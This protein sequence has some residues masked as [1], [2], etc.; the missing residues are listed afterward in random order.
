MPLTDRLCAGAKP[1]DRPRYLI[2]GEGLYL[3]ISRTGT[4]TWMYRSRTGG[5]QWKKL[6][7]YPAMTL[8][9]ARNRAAEAAGNGF[10]MRTVREAYAEY[11]PVLRRS[12]G[13]HGE[14]E[15]RFH[16]DILPRLGEQQLDRVTRVQVSQALQTIVARGALVAANRTLPDLKNF[17]AWCVEKGWINANPAREITRRSVGGKEKSRERALTEDELRRFIPHLDKQTG[18]FSYLTRLALGLILLTGQR[19]SEVLGYDER[20]R[21]GCWWTIPA[22]RT[23]PRRAQKVYLSPQARHLF[24]LAVQLAGSRPF[25]GTTHRIISKAVLRLQFDPPFTPHDLRRTMSTRLADMG[26]MPHV[27]EKML[28]HRMEGTMAIYNRAEYLPERQ[29]A[30]RLWGRWLAKIR[31]ET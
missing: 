15:R 17:F 14:I 27:I 22:E 13:S 25:E 30:W 5:D 26:V 18:R 21:A 7:R 23:K 19:P 10:V 20:E 3:K 8:L 28:N 11:L 2:D 6:G 4:K 16:A 12:Y 29:A 9:Q 1:A 24:K 31:R